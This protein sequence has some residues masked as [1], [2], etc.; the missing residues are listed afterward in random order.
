MFKTTLVVSNATVNTDDKIVPMQVV[1]LSHQFST[2]KKGCALYNIEKIK[3]VVRECNN[4]DR[5]EVELV[6][7]PV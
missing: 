2:L 3:D 5:K 7:I 6:A 4:N 1:N